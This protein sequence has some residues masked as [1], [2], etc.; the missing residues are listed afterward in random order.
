MEWGFADTPPER[1]GF[2]GCLQ[3]FVARSSLLERETDGQIRHLPAGLLGPSASSPLGLRME[4]VERG[5]RFVDR[6]PERL[7]SGAVFGFASSGFGACVGPE[8]G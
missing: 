3:F 5:G 2:C 1:L 4:R 7:M 6:P 8:R